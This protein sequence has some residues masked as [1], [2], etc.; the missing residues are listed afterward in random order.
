MAIDIEENFNVIRFLVGAGFGGVGG[1]LDHHC[2]EPFGLILGSTLLVLQILDHNDVVVMPWNNRSRSVLTSTFTTSLNS[3]EEGMFSDIGVPIFV[4]NNV[5]TLTGFTTG[6]ILGYK[7]VDWTEHVSALAEDG[8]RLSQD[9]A[10][11]LL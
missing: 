7:V 6:Y 2:L 10:P 4:K 3:G 11:V 5:D 1:F 9:E 8:F